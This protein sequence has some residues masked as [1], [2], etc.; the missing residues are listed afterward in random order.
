MAT[1]TDAE[2][3]RVEQAFGYVAEPEPLENMVS[4]VED[5][6]DGRGVA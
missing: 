2:R 3:A 5:I 4:V 1:L 6:L